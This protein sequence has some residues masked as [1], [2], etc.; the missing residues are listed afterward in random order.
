M[1]GNTN[2]IGFDGE[3]NISLSEAFNLDSKIAVKQ[4]DNDKED[5]AWLRPGFTLQTTASFKIVDQVKISGDLLLQ[6]ET[7]AKIFDKPSN[8]PT[9][10]YTAKAM[11]AFADISVGADYQYN[12]QISAFFRVNNILG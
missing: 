11:K 3:L 9:P 10:T 5:Y 12:K 7:R 4:Y 8:F 6:G 1:T 2:V